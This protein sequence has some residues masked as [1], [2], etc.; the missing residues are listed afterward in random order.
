M[1]AQGASTSRIWR[2]DDGCAPAYSSARSNS[3]ANGLMNVTSP[4]VRLAFRRLTE[5]TFPSMAVLSYNE[6]IPGVE[7][8][9]VGM[10]SA[11]PVAVP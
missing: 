8:Y 5:A 7:V 11:E 9:S 1:P 6:I 4:S 10:V 2:W 3:S